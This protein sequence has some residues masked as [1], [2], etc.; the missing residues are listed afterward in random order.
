MPLDL[1]RLSPGQRVQDPFL[2]LEIDQRDSARGSFTTLTLGN[3]RGRLPTAPFWPRDQ[4]RIAG[5]AVGDVV[6]VSAEL[7]LYRGAR[8]LRVD[9]MEPLPRSRVS[10]RELLPSAGD[11]APDWDT[12][13]RWRHELSRP[14]V[15][16]VL[17]LFFDDPKFRSRF[18]E[19]P[20]STQG[21][22]AMLGGL[23][24][25]TREVATIGMAIAAVCGAEADLVLAGALLHDVGKLEAYAWNGTFAMTDEGALLGHVALGMLMLGRTVAQTT[26]APCTARELTLLQ[27]LIASHHGMLEF[28]AAA[29]P[30][31]LE[32]EV[33]HFADNASA[34]T[35]SMAEVL[36]DPDH[37]TGT[38]LLS[39]RSLWQLDR[40][41]AY[42]GGSDW[43]AKTER[44][45]SRG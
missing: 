11:P 3:C 12:L 28:G 5:I 10:W 34:K 30:M 33:L 14:R 23:L 4:A 38:S 8:Q 15:G 24:R 7:G 20:A 19:C 32:A 13:D 39:G 31:T 35:T 40:R 43:G 16:A 1:K 2:V 26:P 17:S 27:H 42:R 25:H 44:P 9:S 18:E 6:Q 22:H 29:P 36:A 45:P 37:F 41:R 21:H